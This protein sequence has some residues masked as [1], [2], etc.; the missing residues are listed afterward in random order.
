M[1]PPKVIKCA[2]PGCKTKIE[3][4]LVFCRNCRRR[5]PFDQAEHVERMAREAPTTDSAKMAIDAAIA[6]LHSQIDAE[7]T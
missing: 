3:T 7:Q 6:E 4:P 2:L 1:T 5:L